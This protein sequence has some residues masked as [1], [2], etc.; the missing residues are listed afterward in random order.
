M[1]AVLVSTPLQ[2]IRVSSLPAHSRVPLFPLEVISHFPSL[3]V[4]L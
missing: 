2:D 1:V 3:V 4:N